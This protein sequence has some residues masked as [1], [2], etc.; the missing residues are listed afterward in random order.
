MATASS[1]GRDTSTGKMKLAVEFWK[2]KM[3][4]A[5]RDDLDWSGENP[6]E[7]GD[8]LEAKRRRRS[9]CLRPKLT[10]GPS[11]RSADGDE[12]MLLICR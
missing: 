9:F 6:L 12:L 5:V 8:E 11:Q 7:E 10:A 3:E 4:E 1:P 2:K